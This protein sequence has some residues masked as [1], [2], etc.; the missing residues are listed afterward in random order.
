[1]PYSQYRIT[2]TDSGP[3]TVD[4]YSRTNAIDKALYSSFPYYKAK[5]SKTQRRKSIVS[6]R[7]IK[8]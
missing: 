2:F 7:K 5:Q 3:V 1:M 6:A 8:Q 4:A